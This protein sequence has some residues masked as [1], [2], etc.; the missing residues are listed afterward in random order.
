MKIFIERIF[1]AS[2]DPYPLLTALLCLKIFRLRITV[3][4]ESFPESV[5]CQRFV[6]YGPQFH[7]SNEETA[8]RRVLLEAKRSRTDNKGHSYNRQGQPFMRF[9]I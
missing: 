6:R 2:G 9:K 7:L 3:C 5:P 1:G 4:P 8:K